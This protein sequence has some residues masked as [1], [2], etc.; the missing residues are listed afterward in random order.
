MTR[1]NN[2]EGLEESIDFFGRLDEAA[3]EQLG[4]EM[5]I[6]GYDVLAAQK[7]DVAKATSAL[8]SGLSLLLKLDELRVRVGLLLRNANRKKSSLFYGWFVER[9][10]RAQTVL[11]TR[12]LKR[13]VTG[14]GR[15][16]TKRK[17]HY[18]G[19][20]YK[21][22]VKAMA[23]RPFVHVDRPEIQAESRL[24]RFWAEVIGRAEAA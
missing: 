17:V 9:G 12:K 5:A 14:N 8:A 13:R 10:R 20:P 2:V 22:R 23:P 7:R 19:K 3:R 21:M 11:V 6:I 18:E 15:Y 16:G 4:V 1:G 24:A